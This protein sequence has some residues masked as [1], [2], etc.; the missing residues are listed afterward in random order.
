MNAAKYRAEQ[1]ENMLENG[2]DLR[3]EQGF[4]IQLSNYRKDRGSYNEMF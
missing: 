3:L 1:E 2:E 4:T